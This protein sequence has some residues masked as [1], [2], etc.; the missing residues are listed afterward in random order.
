MREGTR[1]TNWAGTAKTTPRRVLSPTGPDDIAKLV[2]EAAGRG[3]RLKAAG[4][5]HSFTGIAV[6]DDILLRLDGYRPEPVVDRETS[7]VTVP[8]GITLRELNP[9]LAHHGL[10][11]PNLGD[12]DAQTL[13]GATSTGTHGTGAKLNGIAAAIVGARL[14]DGTG[15]VRDFGPEDPELAAVALGLGALGV[16]TDLT[17]QCVPAFRL[18]AEEHPMPLDAAIAEFDTLAA[19]N[20]HLD[21]YW[22]PRADRVLVKRNNRAGA[23]RPLSGIKRWWEDE[24]MSNAVYGTACHIGKTFPA[25]VPAITSMS[26][27]LMSSRTFMDESYRVFCTPRRVRFVEM[28]YAL[29]RAAFAPAFAAL[30]GAA[31]KRRI[32]F[33][34]E[35]RVTAPDD[36]WLSTAHGRDSVYFA[37][38]QF[39]GMPYRDYFAEVE[40]VMREHDGRPHWGKLHTRTAADLAGVYPRFADF[41]RL[42]DRLDPQRVFANSYLDRVLG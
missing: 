31:N 4:S 9:L 28:E 27:R 13:A 32:I 11:L 17:I 36:L 14:V 42:R 23:G 33:P 21:L 39:R 8:A 35:I 12:I 26:A 40:A 7:R 1:W 41:Q 15:T 5:G 3:G 37:V 29:P 38:H 22:F 2:S 16:V 34:V 24:V 30:R 10:A 6:A 19:T 18:L 25:T 20:D